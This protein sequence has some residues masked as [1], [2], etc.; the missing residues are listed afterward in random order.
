MFWYINRYY[1]KIR[2]FNA[3][4]FFAEFYTL[5]NGFYHNII[6]NQSF[7][8]KRL[9]F[10][11]RLGECGAENKDFV[12]LRIKIAVSPRQIHLILYVKSRR[13]RYA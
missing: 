9:I 10:F 7:D 11:I 6:K 8:N 13:N 12:H 4:D 2:C 1:I 3:P 5:R